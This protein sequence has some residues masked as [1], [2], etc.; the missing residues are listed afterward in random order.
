MAFLNFGLK[1]G[2]PAFLTV[3]GRGV[4]G[5]TVSGAPAQL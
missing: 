2:I 1:G 3:H 4:G 5:V